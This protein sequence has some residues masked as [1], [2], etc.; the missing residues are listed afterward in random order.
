MYLWLAP[1]SVIAEVAVELERSRRH[2]AQA[3]ETYR[4]RILA[5]NEELFNSGSPETAAN[6]SPAT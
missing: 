5:C 4:A 1:G 2:N 3:I 6:K